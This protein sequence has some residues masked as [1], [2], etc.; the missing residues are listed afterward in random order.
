MGVLM[1]EAL[2]HGQLPYSSLHDDNDVRKRKLNDERLQQPFLCGHSLWTIVN[3]CWNLE[4]VKRPS[5]ID[6]KELLSSI[7]TNRHSSSSKVVNKFPNQ[8]QV[9]SSQD[10]VVIPCEFCDALIDRSDWSTHIGIC[11]QQE[12]IRM[13]QQRCIIS[14]TPIKVQIPCEYCGEACY[15]DNLLEHQANCDH[16]T[17]TPQDT[18]RD[19]IWNQCVNQQP[20]KTNGKGYL[21]PNTETSINESNPN[22]FRGFGPNQYDTTPP[23]TIQGKKGGHSNENRLTDVILVDHP[24]QMP[25]YESNT[26]TPTYA[27]PRWANRLQTPNNQSNANAPTY[28]RPRWANRPQTPNNQSN[29]NTPTYPRPRWANRPQ[30]PNNQSNNNTP[31]YPR[32]RWANRPQTPNNQS[33]NNTPTYPRPRW[34]N[35][36]ETLNNQSNANQSSFSSPPWS[37]TLETL[38]N[39]SNANQSSFSSP[40]WSN[41]LE[42]LNNQSNANQSSFSS[43]PWSNTLETLK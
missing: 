40:P 43:P 32:P 2:S 39:Q 4:A 41:T 30:T 24:Q 33:N 36:L 28:P 42:T 13:E 18:F 1:W 9:P 6:L 15:A 16:S 20:S 7:D 19:S 3:Q 38:N 34:A 11:R 22:S 17:P 5:F 21:M 10:N 37:N 29:N 12:Q 35:T 27:R 14:Q 23:A 26:N 31:T 8:T 25:S